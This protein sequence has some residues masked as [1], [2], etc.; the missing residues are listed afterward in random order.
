[1]LYV[2]S[3]SAKLR[4]GKNIHDTKVGKT[5]VEY[6]A[7][8]QPATVKHVKSFVALRDMNVALTGI[9]IWQHLFVMDPANSLELLHDIRPCRM[10]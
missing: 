1:M 9:I 5:L 8:L 4:T 7:E 3:L 10:S 2:V 6:V